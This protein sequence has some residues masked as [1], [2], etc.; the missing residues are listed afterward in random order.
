LGCSYPRG[1]YDNAFPDGHVR[2]GHGPRGQ[3][4]PPGL[5][6][7]SQQVAKDAAITTVIVFVVKAIVKAIVTVGSGTPCPDF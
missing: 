4:S 5:R 7:D 6:I 2:K 3:F 1:G